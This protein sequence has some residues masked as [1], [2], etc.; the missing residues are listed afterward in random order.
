MFSVNDQSMVAYLPAGEAVRKGKLPSSSSNYK[1][2]DAAEA[3]ITVFLVASRDLKS[4]AGA[5]VN[6]STIDTDITKHKR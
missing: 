3:K 6:V 2:T 5:Y 1:A 4:G